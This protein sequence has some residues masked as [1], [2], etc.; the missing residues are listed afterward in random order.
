MTH[1]LR[2][3]KVSHTALIDA[4]EALLP[5]VQGKAPQ[6]LLEEVQRVLNQAKQLE[7]TKC[8]T[9]KRTDVPG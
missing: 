8:E 9:A 7:G 5:F 6:G 3:L 1:E 4:L 2:F